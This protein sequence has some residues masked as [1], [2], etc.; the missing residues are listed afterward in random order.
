MINLL[1][2]VRSSFSSLKHMYDIHQLQEEPKS[3]MLVYIDDY[4]S[5]NLPCL[6]LFTAC[7]MALKVNF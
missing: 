2:Q 5:V 1:I 6:S 7:S 4:S 3:S